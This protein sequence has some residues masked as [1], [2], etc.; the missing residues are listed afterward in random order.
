M[1]SLEIVK[2]A[3]K[4]M[5]D[6]KAYNISVI[7]ISKISVIG[8]YF[9]ISEGSNRNQIQAISDNVSEELAKEKVFAKQTE[10]YANA[11]WILLDYGDVIMHIFDPESHNFYDLERIWRD[12]EQIPLESLK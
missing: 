12:G 9:I 11:N 8:D 10:G 3:V 5:E 7:D 6:K 2:K 1:E 4:A